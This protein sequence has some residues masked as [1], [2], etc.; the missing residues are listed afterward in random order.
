MAIGRSSGLPVVGDD[1]GGRQQGE[2]QRE[3]E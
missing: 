1:A 3:R 2:Y